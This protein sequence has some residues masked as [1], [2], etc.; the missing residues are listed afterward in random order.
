MR[1]RDRD[2]KVVGRFIT[3][4]ELDGNYASEATE[5]YGCPDCGSLVYD[6]EK[7]NLSHVTSAIGIG[8]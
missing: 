7:H 5:V 6:R 4:T 2:Y 8:I 3:S 1:R